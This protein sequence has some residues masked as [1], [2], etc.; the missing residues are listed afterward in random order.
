MWS[1]QNLDVFFSFQNTCIGLLDILLLLPFSLGFKKS[2]G[3]EL[4]NE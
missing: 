2:K 1:S 3:D 4:E